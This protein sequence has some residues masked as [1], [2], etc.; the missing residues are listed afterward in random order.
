MTPQVPVPDSRRVARPAKADERQGEAPSDA[1]ARYAAYLR[2]EHWRD[3]KARYRA[4]NLPQTCT[5]CGDPKV[6]L[7]HRTYQRLGRE[8]LTDLV[9]LCR[10]H[11]VKAHEY[12]DTLTPKQR[13]KKK[14][15]HKQ[16]AYI[17]RLG[18][19]PNPEMTMRAARKLTEHL[20]R[21]RAKHPW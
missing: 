8:R 6:A 16:L 11:H 20:Q 14:A 1:K 3:V 15:T 17:R 2:S 10:E 13:R 7:H 12:L 4:S 21:M 18:G 9:P 5:V 19:E